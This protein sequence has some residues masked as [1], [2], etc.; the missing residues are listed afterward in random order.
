MKLSDIKNYEKNKIDIEFPEMDYL[1]DEII[2]KKKTKNFSLSNKFMKLMKRPKEKKTSQKKIK[3]NS[4]LF[5]K[6]EFKK[7]FN[8]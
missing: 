5:S 4:C 6:K 7:T 2:D 3:Y 1:N 8:Y